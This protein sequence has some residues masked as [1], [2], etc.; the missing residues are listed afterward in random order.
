MTFHAYD[1]RTPE[2]RALLLSPEGST[3]TPRLAPHRVCLDAAARLRLV[4]LLAAL[5]LM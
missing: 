1:A 5:P 2:E 3:R 4:R